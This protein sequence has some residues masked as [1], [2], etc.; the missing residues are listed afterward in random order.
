MPHAKHLMVS[1]TYFHPKIIDDSSAI[2]RSYPSFRNLV[3][4]EV[5]VLYHSQIGLLYDVIL[6][7]SPNLTSLIF[8]KS[9]EFREF[10]GHPQEMEVVKLFLESARVLQRMT[11]G[12]SSN[13]LEYLN[14]KKPTAKEVEDAN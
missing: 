4:L 10:H 5:T 3:S 9:I 8:D 2:P 7:V 11:L 1:D 6:Q 12:S 13:H 14:E